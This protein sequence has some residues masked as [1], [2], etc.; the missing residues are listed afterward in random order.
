MIGSYGTDDYASISPHPT[1]PIVPLNDEVKN[2][3]E[4]NGTAVLGVR[5]ARDIE[6]EIDLR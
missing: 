6:L 3:L 4:A 1:L 2:E 5:V